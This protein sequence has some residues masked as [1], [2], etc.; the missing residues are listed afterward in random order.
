MRVFSCESVFFDPFLKLGNDELRSLR[1]CSTEGKEMGPK[2]AR[3]KN[4]AAEGARAAIAEWR[5]ERAG[6][7]VVA[8]SDGLLPSA[9]T[10]GRRPGGQKGCMPLTLMIPTQHP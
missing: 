10:V 5:G 3:G 6:R 1:K 2:E 9:A 8:P 4:S 7:G